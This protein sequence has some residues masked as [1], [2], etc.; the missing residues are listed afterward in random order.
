MRYD[1]AQKAFFVADLS[2]LGAHL[3]GRLLPNDAKIWTRVPDNATFKLAGV[4]LYIN[5]ERLI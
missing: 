3:D 4:N 5:F 1:A 2:S